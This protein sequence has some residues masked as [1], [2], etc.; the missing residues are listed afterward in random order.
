M[1]IVT[2]ENEN[3]NGFS[4]SADEFVAHITTFCKLLT[5]DIRNMAASQ[6][7][8]IPLVDLICTS[9]TQ[10]YLNGCL[11]TLN[12]EDADCKD[13]YVVK[14]RS[15]LLPVR[16]ELEAM[17]RNKQREAGKKEDRRSGH[18]NDGTGHTQF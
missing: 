5:A 16:I 10:G 11:D 2:N 9:V 15:L 8:K 13:E 3:P 18:G 7:Q 17:L 4:A 1:R 12:S 6:H 14:L